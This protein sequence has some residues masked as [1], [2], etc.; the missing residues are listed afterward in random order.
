MN[1]WQSSAEA[2]PQWTAGGVGGEGQVPLIRVP[3][4]RPLIHMFYDLKWRRTRPQF[5]SHSLP[6]LLFIRP[7]IPH[8]PCCCAPRRASHL[9]SAAGCWWAGRS[10]CRIT[11]SW[12]YNYLDIYQGQ[13]RWF[14]DCFS[15]SEI[16]TNDDDSGKTARSFWR[17]AVDSSRAM[18]LFRC[19]CPGLQFRCT[20]GDW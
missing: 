6:W 13:L 1:W 2:P 7:S 4:R 18:K 9:Y 5:P 17:A 14:T 11:F 12:R 8:L 10:R 15:N 19:P 3:F 16:C 20:W